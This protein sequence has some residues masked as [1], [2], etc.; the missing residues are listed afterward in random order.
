MFVP[1]ESQAKST[2]RTT[3]QEGYVALRGAPHRHFQLVLA[4]TQQVEIR[5]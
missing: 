2:A 4:N 1:R 5:F 3:A